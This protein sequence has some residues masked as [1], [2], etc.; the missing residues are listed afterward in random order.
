MIR[1][2]QQALTGEKLADQVGAATKDL[3]SAVSKLSKVRR[4]WQAVMDGAG[5]SLC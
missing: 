2:L 5:A 4:H 3:H 1:E